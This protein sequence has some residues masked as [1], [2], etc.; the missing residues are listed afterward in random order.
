MISI[1]SCSTRFWR[2]ITKDGWEATDTGWLLTI[3]IEVII[4]VL[5]FQIDCKKEACISKFSQFLSLKPSEMGDTLAGIFAA[6]VFIWIIVTVFLQRTELREQRS[7][8]EAQ[9]IATQ[10]MAVA[11]SKQVELLTAQAQIFENE[12]LQRSEEGKRHLFDAYLSSLADD[13]RRE[14]NS[15]S[16]WVAS[17][18][19]NNQGMSSAKGMVGLVEL[20]NDDLVKDLAFKLPIIVKTLDEW[21]DKDHVFHDRPTKDVFERM[22]GKT[23]LALEIIPELSYHHQERAVSLYLGRIESWLV[24]FLNHSAWN[25]PLANER[26]EQ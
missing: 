4:I 22:L 10:Q 20:P 5:G 23:R 8:F 25:M 17:R 14:R 12:Q 11:Q 15:G 1:R 26:P 24:E 2:S 3:S 9:R 19:R 6:L 21:I 13:I 18:G 16:W 7:E